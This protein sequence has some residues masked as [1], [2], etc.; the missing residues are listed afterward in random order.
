MVIPFNEMLRS[1][2]FK[3][4]I[5]NG[6]QNTVVVVHASAIA[7]TCD[8]MN[9]LI[10]GAMAEAQEASAEIKDINFDDFV[11]FCE[12]AYRGDYTVP[13]WTLDESNV[14]QKP[15]EPR[16]GEFQTS[17]VQHLAAETFRP[18]PPTPVEDDVLVVVDN[19]QIITT[20]SHTGRKKNKK[21]LKRTRFKNRN[22]SVPEP[23][24]GIITAGFEP[25]ANN[26]PTQNFTPVFLA[27]AHLYKF[28][29]L[30]LIEPLKALALKKLKW[31]L[32]NF[33]LYER[34]LGD[35]LELAR[36]AYNDIDIP[37][38]TESGKID[39]LR[40]LVVE[41]IACEIDTI[42]KSKELSELL[43]DGGEFASDL[44]RRVHPLLS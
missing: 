12:Y 14:S 37:P 8:Y 11:R 22:Y 19:P 31:T 36:Y 20:P 42:G 27:H 2:Q 24:I 28:A 9:Q 40:S 33:K 16:E 25:D 1:A 21:T 23:P 3:F 6:N 41:F 34:R 39:D 7:A 5:S 30:R 29:H 44:W 17:F 26:H 10:N 18:P 4:I 13:T 38:R 35:I 43:E 32:M 15:S